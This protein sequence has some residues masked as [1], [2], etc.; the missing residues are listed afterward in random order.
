VKWYEVAEE[1]YHT[2][3]TAEQIEELFRAGRLR[4]TDACREAGQQQWRTMD[5]LFPL[6]KYD[7]SR[8]LSGAAPNRPGRIS[9]AFDGSDEPGDVKRP[10]SSALKAGWI[11]FGFG[12]AI[13]W[14]F[15]FGHA[16]F[17]IALITAVVAMCT[18]Q[19]N[20]GLALLLSSF[21]ASGLCALIFLTLVVGAVGVAAGAAISE[22]QKQREQA[23]QRRTANQPAPTKRQQRPPI[24][25]PSAAPRGSSVQPHQAPVINPFDQHRQ[26]QFAMA[27]QRQVDAQRAADQRQRDRNVYEAERQ[28]AAT[29]ARE[30]ERQRL[31]SS[32]DWWDNQVKGARLRGAD[33]RWLER[34]REEAWT[35]RQEFER[36]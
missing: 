12:L 26:H 36:R 8:R 31:Q 33:F 15:P 2:P 18:H 10:V 25:S 7:S 1:G 34:Q 9:S 19:V 28:R 13:A 3:L 30:Q 23:Q 4:R 32:V 22:A 29:R 14:W 27:Q 17:S 21:V 16:F 11:C 6:L 24:I 35:R 5:E 20:R